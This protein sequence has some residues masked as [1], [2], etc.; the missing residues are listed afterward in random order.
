M[1]R[2]AEFSLLLV[3]ALSC[4]DEAHGAVHFLLVHSLPPWP[5]EGPDSPTTTIARIRSTRGAVADEALH[6]IRERIRQ[7]A[8]E[9]QLRRGDAVFLTLR[10]LPGRYERGLRPRTPALPC[11]LRLVAQT[12]LTRELAAHARRGHTPSVRRGVPVR[13]AL[14]VLRHEAGGNC[15]RLSAATLWHSDHKEC[16]ELVSV[17]P[18]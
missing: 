7:T 12:V 2:Q 10:A 15:Q 4:L 11:V 5:V 3:R 9:Q 13:R 1:L 18:V 14:P 8:A 17:L 16:V 6:L